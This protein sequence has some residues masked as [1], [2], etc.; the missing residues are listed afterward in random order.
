MPAAGYANALEA[1]FDSKNFTGATPIAYPHYNH[2]TPAVFGCMYTTYSPY[3]H[4]RK[5]SLL[6]KCPSV[7][8]PF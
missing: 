1:G 3:D 4:Y 5:I 2:A 6:A 7:V 8:T